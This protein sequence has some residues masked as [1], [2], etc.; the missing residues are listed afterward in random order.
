MK[1]DGG[2]EVEAVGELSS[3]CF[4]FSVSFS[5]ASVDSWLLGSLD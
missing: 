3:G 2:G 4:G 1:I 5:G